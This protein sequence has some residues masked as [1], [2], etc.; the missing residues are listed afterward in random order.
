VKAVTICN[1]CGNAFPISITGCDECATRKSQAGVD[2]ETSVFVELRLWAGHNENV[3]EK[4]NHPKSY[5]DDASGRRLTEVGGA[6]G[7]FN[8][9]G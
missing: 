2:D 7:F 6:G 4:I 1:E 3:S 5:K 9:H 8:S